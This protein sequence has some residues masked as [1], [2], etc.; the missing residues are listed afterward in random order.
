MLDLAADVQP[1]A[2]MIENVRGLLDPRFS[3]YRAHI[4]ERLEALGY[5]VAGWRL[6]NASDYGVPQ[7]RPRVVMVALKRVYLSRF[8]WPA[9]A[10][11]GTPTVGEAL[12]EEMRSRGW[13]GAAEWKA[14]A[15]GIAPTLVGGSRKHGGPDLGPTRARLAWEKLGVNGKLLAAQAPG[16]DHVGPPA[17]TVRMAAIVQGFPPEW[18]FAG[19]KTQAYRQVGN[20]FPPPVAEAVGRALAAAIRSERKEQPAAA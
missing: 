12:Y 3:D 18:E 8:E 16:P 20:A 14:G 13:A 11:G 7:L 19:R 10:R 1:K 2:I 9:P 6:L 17:L 15:E 5:G 4:G